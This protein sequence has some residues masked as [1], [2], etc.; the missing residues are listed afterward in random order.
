MFLNGQNIKVKRDERKIKGNNIYTK[1]VPSMCGILFFVYEP[2]YF[3]AKH[4][5]FQ[6]HIIKEQTMCLQC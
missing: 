1:T 4:I 6:L 3:I 5:Q 2:K